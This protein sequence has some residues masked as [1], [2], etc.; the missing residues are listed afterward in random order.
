MKIGGSACTIQLTA[1]LS[2]S[3]IGVNF[4]LRLDEMALI[5]MS[6]EKCILPYDVESP[7]GSSMSF[8]GLKR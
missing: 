7:M 6:T 2:L 1:S 5:L 4:G 3:S 8:Y